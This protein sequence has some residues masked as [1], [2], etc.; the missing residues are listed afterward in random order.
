MRKSIKVSNVNAVSHVCPVGY[1]FNEALGLLGDPARV[2]G[3]VRPDGLKQLVL[4]V[5]LEGR[6][7]DEHLVHQHAEG[8]P[9]H[10]E[11]VL[12][13]EE[14]LRGETVSQRFRR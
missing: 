7:A 9:V 12:L 8:P 14:D 11:G 2:V 13:S 6:L 1:L 3:G 10:R 4:V 5:A